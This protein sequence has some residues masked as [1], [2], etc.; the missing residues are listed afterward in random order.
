MRAFVAD[1]HIHTCLSPCGSLRMSPRAIVAAARSGGLDLIAVTDHNT[2][3]MVEEV[4]RAARAAGLHV[5]P[6]I[7]VETQEEVHLLA[8]FDDLSSC[9][10]FAAEVYPFLPDRANDPE[11]F[12]DQVAVDDDETIVYAE[13][14]LLLN[15][16]ALSLEEV[17]ARVVRRGGL[18]VPAH[19]DR[20]PYG[21]VT[22]LGFGPEDL[23]FP[24]VEV[25]GS[26]RPKECGPGAAQW[27]S[28]AHV[29][30]VIGSR[31]S[32]FRMKGPT[33]DEIRRAALGVGGRSIEIRRGAKRMEMAG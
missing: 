12:G 13:A 23:R 4:A 26:S 31:V 19:V 32:V 1:L 3:G 20:T 16:L 9:Q 29:P 6:G 18:V 22:Q 33:V 27:S 14:K 21:L 7:E 10:D 25:D 15:A 17:V 5:L 30:E 8:Y 2:A 28:D 11:L 24:L